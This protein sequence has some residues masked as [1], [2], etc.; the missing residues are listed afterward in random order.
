METFAHPTVAVIIPVFNQAH[1]LADAIMS[2][3]AQ[4]RPADEIIVVDDG[5]TDDPAAVLTQFKAVRLIRQDNRGLSAARNAGLQ[6]CATS[7]VVFLDADDRLLPTALEMGLACIAGR[8]DCAFVYGGYRHISTN[9]DPFGPNY[10]R[11]IDGDAHLAFLRGNKI[12][13]PASVLY[14]RD[15][16]LEV[17]GF[18][19]T[20]RR[21]QDHDIYLRITQRHPVASH[22]EIVAEYRKHGQ[23]M[24]NDHVAQLR[25]A[26][27][28]LDRHEVR[29]ATDALTRASL[30]DGRAHKR[31]Y[32]V[33]Q[34]LAA[35]AARWRA[36]HRIGVFVG[37][38]IQAARWSPLFTIRTLLG[39]FGRREPVLSACYCAVDER[40]WGAP[41]RSQLNLRILPTLG[42]CGPISCGFHRGRCTA[43][44]DYYSRKISG[45][46]RG[47]YSGPYARDCQSRNT[48][49][50]SVRFG[51]ERVMRAERQSGTLDQIGLDT[52][53]CFTASL[54]WLDCRNAQGILKA[55][56]AFQD[57]SLFA[58]AGY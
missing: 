20:L 25:E 2:V 45:S 9:G 56:A 11:Q 28:V 3:L 17:N 1:F 39:A 19:E 41:C 33:S 58:C 29:I 46:E 21:V 36:H 4:T 57:Q 44:D 53:G 40:I 50:L 12:G 16:L 55:R 47:R 35:A 31:K 48:I 22:P 18:D 42:D 49:R 51:G 27:L 54:T 52:F 24:S 34:M 7:H 37:D 6:S 26:L 23:N 32:Y 38:L 5:S 8:P 15:C 30:R 14:R 10:L 43:V 13:V